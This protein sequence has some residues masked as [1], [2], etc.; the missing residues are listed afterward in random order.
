MKHV[1]SLLFCLLCWLPFGIS[2]TPENAPERV[3]SEFSCNLPGPSDLSASNITTNSFDL[4]WTAVPGAWGYRVRV[5]DS[6]NNQVFDNTTTGIAMI[7]NGLAGGENYTATVTTLCAVGYEGEYSEIPVSTNIVIDILI[8]N[9][10][11]PNSNGEGRILP[12][13]DTIKIPVLRGL[14]YI[15]KYQVGNESTFFTFLIEDEEGEPHAILSQQ[16]PGGAGDLTDGWQN[17]PI[18]SN[19]PLHELDNAS[20]SYVGA[21]SGLLR[22]H[23]LNGYLNGADIDTILLFNSINTLQCKFDFIECYKKEGK[24]R[25]NIENDLD[26]SRLIVYPNPTSQFININNSFAGSESIILCQLFDISG[27]ELSSKT[28]NNNEEIK[29]DIVDLPEG[30]YCVKIKTT[31]G[32]YTNS[33]YKRF[34]E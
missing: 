34:K 24:E 11:C 1:T 25:I 33:F 2:G 23:V 16:D 20:V 27:R 6:N 10:S 14:E 21:N 30:L 13:G 31:L 12:S 15:A 17:F 8:T 5:T 18:H 3:Q 26:Q 7:V 19:N 28:I 4:D 22:I 9:F 29:L 32:V